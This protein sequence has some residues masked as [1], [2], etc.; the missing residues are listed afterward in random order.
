MS[1]APQPNRTSHEECH[2]TR[3]RELM[4]LVENYALRTRELSEAV[5][6]LGGHITAERE[7]RETLVEIKRIRSLLDKAGVDLL[8]FVER[9][10]H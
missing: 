7:I 5:A 9:L 10:E 8:A 3:G 2:D 6:L 4:R 1:M